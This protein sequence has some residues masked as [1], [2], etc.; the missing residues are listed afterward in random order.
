MARAIL[1]TFVGPP[2]WSG[3][4]HV[5]SQQM[6]KLFATALPCAHCVAHTPCGSRAVTAMMPHAPGA[7]SICCV[8]F[9]KSATHSRLRRLTLALPSDVAA[10]RLCE[11]SEHGP[12]SHKNA[13]LRLLGDGV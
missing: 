10:C 4:F 9:F 5:P 13:I 6:I 3:L 8:A 12:C 2:P 1:V 11:L 7:I